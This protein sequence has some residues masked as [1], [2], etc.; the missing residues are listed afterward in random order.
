VAYSP[1]LPFVAHDANAAAY[2]RWAAARLRGEADEPLARRGGFAGAQ[3]GQPVFADIAHMLI[4]NY[5]V[6]PKKG[7]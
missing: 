3:T 2:L 6:K 5:G 7:S 4:N 1:R